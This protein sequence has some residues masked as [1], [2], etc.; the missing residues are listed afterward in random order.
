[1]SKENE[2][3]KLN[4][5]VL[6]NIAVSWINDTKIFVKKSTYVKYN[7]II[8]LYIIPALGNYY[9]SEIT[10]TLIYNWSCDLLSSG[11]SKKTGLSSKTVLDSISV[12][13]NMKKYAISK[14]MEV[15]F[16]SV[17]LP[18]KKK[19]KPLDVLTLLEQQILCEYLYKNISLINLGIL[20]CLFTGIRIG[21]LCALKWEDI[22]FA[23]KNMHIHK[24]MQRL[25]NEKSEINKT[26]I[27][28]SSPKSDCS[29]RVIPIPDNLM[30]LLIQWRQSNDAVFLTGNS[31][32]FI[33]PRTMQNQFKR[34][35]KNCNIKNTN[36]HTLRHTF[37][38][39]CVEVEFDIKSLSEILGHSN[40]N[41]T[42]NRYVHPTM[43]L[44]RS[45]MSKLSDFFSAK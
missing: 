33:E 21:E 44:K 40:V 30:K 22:S 1:M 32:K 3:N 5:D 2:K 36:F 8:N 35:L 7:N 11:G 18:I 10:N 13:M 39:R 28:I 14:N 25:Q 16:T 23:E 41:I 43:E 38:T 6:E 20:T 4:D 17:N 9:I 19:T 42:L 27:S 31:K 12:L 29:I 24:T 34:I 15:K 37:A 45:N 26:H